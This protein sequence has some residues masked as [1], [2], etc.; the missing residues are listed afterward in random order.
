MEIHRRGRESIKHLET[1]Q[2]TRKLTSTNYLE[3]TSR[4]QIAIS[5][6]PKERIVYPK[7]RIMKIQD[8]DKEERHSLVYPSQCACIMDEKNGLTVQSRKQC[9]QL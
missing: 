9:H 7:T 1:R 5:L 6:S 2:P 3:L 8:G 4:T